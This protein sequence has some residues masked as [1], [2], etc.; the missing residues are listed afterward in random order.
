MG[1]VLDFIP[2]RNPPGFTLNAVRDEAGTWAVEVADFYDTRIPVH[3][4]F[5]EVA[6]A[7]IP[8]AGGMI[9]NAEQLEPTT[10]GCIVANMTLY[11]DGYIELRTRPIDTPDRKGWFAAALDKIKD[12]ILSGSLD[13]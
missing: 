12:G 11:E 4:M 5:R 3:E 7:L 8:I 10:R 6:D 2:G 13:K 1:E 9:H